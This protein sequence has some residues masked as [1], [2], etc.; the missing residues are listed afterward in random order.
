VYDVGEPVHFPVDAVS[1]EPSRTVPEIVGSE[2]FEGAAGTVVVFAVVAVVLVVVVAVVAAEPSA[3][4]TAN[5]APA[6]QATASALPPFT[7][8]P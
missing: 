4:E 5:P 6:M 7:F 3:T 2:V 8:P 1:T